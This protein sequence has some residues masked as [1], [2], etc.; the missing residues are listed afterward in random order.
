MFVIRQQRGTKTV[1][2]ISA[3]PQIW[4]ER[5]HAMRFYT[6]GDARR[7]ATATG[8]S[9]DWSINPAGPAQAVWDEG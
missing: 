8:V 2:L 1:W 3:Y 7:M 9:G 4:G 5:D 6:R